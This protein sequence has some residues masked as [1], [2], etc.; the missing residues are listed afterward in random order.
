MPNADSPAVDAAVSEVRAE[1]LRADQK[2]AAL[3]ALV[4]AIAAGVVTLFLVRKGGFFSLWNGV[5]WA[6]WGGMICLAASLGNLLLCVRPYGV[7][8]PAGHSYFSFYALYEGRTD[9]LIRHL[10]STNG[11]DTER[12]LQLIELSVLVKRKYRMI[13][14]AV[15]LLGCSLALITGAILANAL[16]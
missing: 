9:Q 14:I 10:E 6:S 11:A 16:Q 8:K 7:G 13:T 2:A 15:D 1:L 4:S 3:L 12:C 5:E